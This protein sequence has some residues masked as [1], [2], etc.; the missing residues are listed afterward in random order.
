LPKLL[1][2]VFGVLLLYW[3]TVVVIAATTF[4]LAVTGVGEDEAATR[5]AVATRS[6]QATP[7]PRATA[8]PARPA[9]VPGTAVLV[10][11]DVV[12][13][14]SDERRFFSLRCEDGLLAVSTTAETVFATVDCTDYWVPDD[15]LRPFLGTRVE[16]RVAVNQPTRLFIDSEAGGTLR[17]DA[18]A[19]WIDE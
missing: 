8:T 4:A 10:T 7:S 2:V 5:T 9:D 12:L 15:V 1:L 11:E 3:A 17:F 19:V 13:P 14:E 16:V 18:T 6:P